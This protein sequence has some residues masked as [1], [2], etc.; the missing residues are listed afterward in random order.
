M[1]APVS[2]LLEAN[3][4]RLLS[5]D[6]AAGTG[7]ASA[8][9]SLGA[10]VIEVPWSPDAPDVMVDALRARL[11]AGSGAPSTIVL[12]VG[13]AFLEVAKPELPPLEVEARRAVLWRD[14]DRYFPITEPVAVVCVGDLALA[15]PA[16]QLEAWVRAIEALGPVKA[17]VTA[18]QL[19][20]RVLGSGTGSMP[21]GFGEHGVIQGDEGRL[22][23]ARRAPA[24][25]GLASRADAQVPPISMA[26]VLRE[27][28][29][30]SDASLAVQLLDAPLAAGLRRS[31]QRR[32]LA[33]LALAAVSLLA[34]LW[35]ADHRRASQL[36]ALEARAATLA[37]R[38]APA[39]R[40]EM[41]RT[42]AHSELSLLRDADAQ[43]R[44]PD[45]P[46]AVLAALGRVLPRDAFVQRL[47]WNG[48]QWRVEGTAD[49]APRLV[50]LLDGD[51]EFR[52]VRIASASQRFLDA[53]RPRE[54]FAISFRLRTNPRGSDDTP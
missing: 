37:E 25:A 19:G 10:P 39:M 26:A 41:R 21:A 20:A 27:A 44:A 32:L 17:I 28:L 43:G 46:L 40:A 52:D 15:T 22:V 36:A 12:V 7:G 2:L 38:A 24:A 29:T 31:R 49:D 9:A 51:A 11:G 6:R 16:R 13:L 33:S 35:S 23:S 47:E 54:S 53:G 1:S 14:A 18:P 8:D 48:Q 4:V 42:R 30:W 3:A 5:R 50:P 45:T 34:L